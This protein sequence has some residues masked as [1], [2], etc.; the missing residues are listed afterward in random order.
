MQSCFHDRIRICPI[1]VG[2]D[3]GQRMIYLWYDMLGPCE[4]KRKNSGEA[5]VLSLKTG[6]SRSAPHAPTS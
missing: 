1:L 3:P 4:A 6:I 2:N 5:T